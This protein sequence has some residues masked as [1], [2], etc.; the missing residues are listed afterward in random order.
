VSRPDRVEVILRCPEVCLECELLKLKKREVN[1]RGQVRG[2]PEVTGAKLNGR[3]EDRM[4]HVTCMSNHK[5]RLPPLSRC[6]PQVS[7][8]YQADGAGLHKS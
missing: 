4:S 5:S 2:Y 7:P 8:G 1:S 6:A 3:Q